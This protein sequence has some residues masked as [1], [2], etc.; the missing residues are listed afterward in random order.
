MSVAEHI[1]AASIARVDRIVREQSAR[2]EAEIL[3]TIQTSRR[4]VIV[5]TDQKVSP[6]WVGDREV[7]RS[8]HVPLGTVYEYDPSLL[9]L[10]AGLGEFRA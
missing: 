1:P 6:L 7:V 3:R 5:N 10:R 8:P 9:D 2:I 4:A